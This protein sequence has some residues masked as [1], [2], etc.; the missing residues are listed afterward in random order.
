MTWKPPKE[1][2][3]GTQGLR[4]NVE[5][6][7][8]PAVLT[9]AYV[10]AMLSG[11]F[12]DELGIKQRRARRSRWIGASCRAKHITMMSCSSWESVHGTWLLYT[13]GKA[14]GQKVAYGKRL[15]T[16]YAGIPKLNAS[17]MIGYQLMTALPSANIKCT[18]CR[19]S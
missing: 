16:A 14:L 5:G 8:T 9:S 3:N 10:H 1:T 13:R 4:A 12:L 18:G 17:G 15:K 11:S 19:C 6:L 7:R 2:V